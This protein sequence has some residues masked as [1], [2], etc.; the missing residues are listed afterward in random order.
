VRARAA[1]LLLGASLALAGC[2]LVPTGGSP[3]VVAKVPFE[4]LAPTIPGTNGARVQFVTQPVYVVDATGHLTPSSR[5]VPSP[6]T[7]D[8]V[9]RELVLGPTAIESSAG[10]TSALPRDLVILQATIRGNVGVIALAK[11]LSALSRSQEILAVGQLVFTAHAVGATAGVEVTVGGVPEKLRL[12]AGTT[13]VR[14]SEADYASL[15]NP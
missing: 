10:F 9:L 7:L 13:R 8:S 12:P 2:T 1:V 11:P 5:I 6:P 3:V 4:L 14:V 15:L